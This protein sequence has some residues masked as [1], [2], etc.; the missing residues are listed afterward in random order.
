MT[1]EGVDSA[2]AP[3]SELAPLAPSTTPR[4]A[5]SGPWP[6]RLWEGVLGYL[7][8]L[9]MGVLAALTWWL[10]KN[11][12]QPRDAAAAAPVSSAPDYTMRGFAV[13]SFGP[14][15]V[16]RSRLEGDLLQHY[17]STDTIE[18]DGVR[19][20]AVDAAGRL[21]LGS[22]QRAL[23]NGDATRVRLLGA[24]RVVREPGPGDGPGARVEILGESL[25]IDTETQRV[26]S[27]EPVTLLTGRGRL[28]AGTLDYSHAE[29]SARLG[30]RVTGELRAVPQ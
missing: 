26:R 12:P 8:V 7:P 6:A 29:G 5:P 25:Q 9:L 10:V 14:D 30:G 17:P 1:P 19:L 11:T 16:L 13:S 4:V 27:D 3:F 21:T 20:R 18:V 2:V 24:A 23:S 15:G 28:R 22:A